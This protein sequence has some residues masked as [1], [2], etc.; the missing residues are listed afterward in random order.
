MREYIPLGER[1]AR[2]LRVQAER[3]RQMATTARTQQVQRGLADLAIRFTRRAVQRE[4]EERL[5]GGQATL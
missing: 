3:Y 2:T 5:A 1:S 4:T